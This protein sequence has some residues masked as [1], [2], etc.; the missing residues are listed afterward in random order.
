MFD[1]LSEVQQCFDVLIS[2]FGLH[3]MSVDDSECLL[4]GDGF[5]LSIAY[6]RDGLDVSYIER[7]RGDW[8]SY[9]LTNF[10]SAQ[11]F[12]PDDRSLYG[13]PASGVDRIRASIRVFASGL[14]NRCADILSGDKAWL[15][16]LKKHDV[17]SWG[18]MPPSAKVT[19]LLFNT[20]RYKSVTPIG[21]RK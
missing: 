6:D 8:L 13:Q 19:T 18:G 3:V 2:R 16:T 14:E 1:F 17:G 7:T 10:L 5:A 20:Y 4:V 21:N 9:R 12:T 11:R 15:M